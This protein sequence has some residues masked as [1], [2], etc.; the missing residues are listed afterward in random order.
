MHPGV[1]RAAREAQRDV[2]A[3]IPLQGPTPSDEPSRPASD[4]PEHDTDRELVDVGVGN[5][6]D[7]RADLR[8]YVHDLHGVDLNQRAPLGPSRATNRTL[9][10][11]RRVTQWLAPY[12]LLG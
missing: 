2:G 1:D 7:V 6:T 12:E 3:L 9:G 11:P 5:D 4:R 8:P 10:V